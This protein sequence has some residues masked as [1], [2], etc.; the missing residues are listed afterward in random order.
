MIKLKK[1]LKWLG[2]VAIKILISEATK[3]FLKNK[4]DEYDDF[5]KYWKEFVNF[6]KNL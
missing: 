3:Q 4:W 6:I 5:E 1:I 2:G